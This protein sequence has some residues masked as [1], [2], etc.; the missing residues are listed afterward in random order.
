MKNKTTNNAGIKTVIDGLKFNSLASACK[1]FKIEWSVVKYRINAGW[2]LNK[3]FKTPIK[4]TI[5]LTVKNKKFA[6]M[7]HACEYY[8]ID[9]CL[10]KSR[11]NR[12]I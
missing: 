8:K 5:S 2:S 3:A 4:K 1:H 6:S 10:V 12:E 9:Y 11:F 7:R